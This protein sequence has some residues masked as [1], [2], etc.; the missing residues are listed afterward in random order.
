MND[1]GN[2]V[3]GWLLHCKTF[4]TFIAAFNQYSRLSGLF[5]W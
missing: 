5:T 4:L 2:V 3:C 1:I